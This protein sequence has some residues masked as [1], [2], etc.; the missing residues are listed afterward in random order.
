MQLRVPLCTSKHMVHADTTPVVGAP[1]GKTQAVLAGNVRK[2]A[3][4]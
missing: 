4:P 2:Q 1:I 3:W